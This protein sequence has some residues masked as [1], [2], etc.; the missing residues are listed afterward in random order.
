MLP[1]RA[2][3]L[4]CFA[5]FLA[6][7]LHAEILLSRVV[8]IADGDTITVL[9]INKNQHKIRL[10]RIDAPD[11]NQAFGD[12]SKKS[13]SELV[14]NKNVNVHWDKQDKYSRKIGKVTLGS[15][16][17]ILSNLGAGWRGTTKNSRVNNPPLFV[18]V[19]RM[20]RKKCVR[21][22]LVCGE[23]LYLHPLGHFERWEEN[24]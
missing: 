13:L 24:L 1:F 16:T 14:A 2:Y 22:K 19:M 12:V 18:E 9:D 20:P 11:K 6:G 4:V 3:S 10:T 17:V 21:K 23:I 8:H 5:V 15:L 7:N